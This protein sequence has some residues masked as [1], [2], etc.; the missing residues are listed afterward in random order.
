MAQRAMSA[1]MADTAHWPIQQLHCE[2][3]FYQS[4]KLL[5]AQYLYILAKFDM[6]I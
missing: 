1:L 6:D 3:K 5:V 2:A 4:S